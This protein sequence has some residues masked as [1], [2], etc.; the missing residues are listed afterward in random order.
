MKKTIQNEIDIINKYD[1]QWNA[2]G[3]FT[4]D[5]VSEIMA[6]T[7]LYKTRDIKLGFFSQ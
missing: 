6:D 5:H 3:T 4:L 2:K 7:I 1:V